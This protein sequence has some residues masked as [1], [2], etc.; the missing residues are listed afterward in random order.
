M[1]TEDRKK[2]LSDLVERGAAIGGKNLPTLPLSVAEDVSAGLFFVAVFPQDQHDAHVLKYDA[3]EPESAGLT[4]RRSDGSLVAYVAP[5][6]EWPELD[7]DDEIARRAR[8]RDYLSSEKNRSDFE[9]FVDT[10]R[11]DLSP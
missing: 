5:L 9:R 2:L 3:A 7:L 8:W 4:F 11:G 6:D 10:C 1:M